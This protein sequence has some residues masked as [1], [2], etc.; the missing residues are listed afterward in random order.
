M[1]DI[2]DFAWWREDAHFRH[3]DQNVIIKEQGM[4][5]SIASVRACMLSIA[6]MVVFGARHSEPV[7]TSPPVMAW[8]QHRGNTWHCVQ[9]AAWHWQ[10]GSRESGLAAN[11]PGFDA[12]IRCQQLQ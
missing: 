3:T 4:Q 9:H 10:A 8:A 2:Q 5:S 12:L 6:V 11:I 1:W 7:R